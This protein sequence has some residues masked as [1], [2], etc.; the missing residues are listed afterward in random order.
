MHA[1]VFVKLLHIHDQCNKNTHHSINIIDNHDDTTV[2]ARSGARAVTKWGCFEVRSV[3]ALQCCNIIQHARHAVHRRAQHVY[4]QPDNAKSLNGDV[5]LDDIN[6][7]RGNVPQPEDWLR[8]WRACKTQVSF[9]AAAKIFETEAFISNRKVPCSRRAIRNLIACMA[10][11]VKRLRM[12][13]LR[14]ATCLSLQVDD[15]GDYRLVRFS[16]DRSPDGT[17]GLS[18][19]QLGRWVPAQAAGVFALSKES[20]SSLEQAADDKS[21]VMAESLHRYVKMACTDWNGNCDNDL[22]NLI[23]QRLC[24]R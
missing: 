14:E 13:K 21:K 15:R 7:L 24:G 8:A 12:Q 4:F 6:L 3:K 9:N 5:N 18:A 19:E 17:P 11:A 2:F 20:V 10:E 16:A 1:A 22:V 23:C